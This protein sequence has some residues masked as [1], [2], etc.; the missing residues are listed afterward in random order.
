[1][2]D[3]VRLE[4]CFA[5]QSDTELA[6][7]RIRSNGEVVWMGG[8]AKWVCLDGIS[9]P[10]SDWR[11]T[12]IVRNDVIQINNLDSMVGSP[13]DGKRYLFHYTKAD[14]ALTHILRVGGFG[15]RLMRT[16]MTQEN[17]RNGYSRWLPR[18]EH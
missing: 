12:E 17:Q 14:T 9:F 2:P 16:S 4:W 18:K 3:N 11:P 1:M 10:T 8:Q 6:E 7:V 15:Y 13:L 5:V